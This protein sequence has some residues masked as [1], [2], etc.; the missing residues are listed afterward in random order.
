MTQQKPIGSGYGPS[1]SAADIVSGVDL[2]G[3]TAI[4]TGG[5]AGLGLEST[6]RLAEAGAQVVV[7]ARSLE[8][9]RTALTG[10]PNVE[11]A[12]LDLTK[13]E[14][15]DRFAS[16]FLASRRPL[17]ILMNSAGIMAT[18]LARDDRGNE[19]QLS[20]NH[21]GHFALVRALWPALVAAHGA[22]V[23]TLS[24][25]GHFY[26]GVDFDDPNFERRDYDPVVAYA[27]AKTACALFA[28]GIDARG[29]DEGIRAFSV[30]PG[31]VITGLSAH[32]GDDIKRQYGAID[33]SG[34]VVIDPDNDKKN[35]EQGASTQTWCAISPQLDGMGGLYCEDC[36]VAVLS[37]AESDVLR[38]VKPWASDPVL[39]DRLWDLS[40]RL[41]GAVF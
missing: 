17:P 32:M 34:A 15:I 41:T 33:E 5:S 9:A 7:L 3:R 6:R 28:V 35:M 26:A 30:H 29:K 39:A 37:P 18:P 1:T 12:H 31:G 21:L 27:Q 19:E 24:S 38:G 2:T 40:E 8:K 22:R 23:V 25:R 13:Q 14:S 20:A 36:D 4:I 10:I 11:I 16:D